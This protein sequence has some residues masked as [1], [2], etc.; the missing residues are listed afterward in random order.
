MSGFLS[1]ST[2]PLGL[3]EDPAIKKL[4]EQGPVKW[5]IRA[6]SRHILD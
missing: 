6:G 1:R 4:L 5:A 3:R 2:Q